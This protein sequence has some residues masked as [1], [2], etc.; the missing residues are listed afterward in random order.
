MNIVVTFLVTNWWLPALVGVAVVYFA[1]QHLAK[2]KAKEAITEYLHNAESSVFASADVGVPVVADA[3]YAMLPV[4][5]RLFLPRVLFDGIVSA[6]WGQARSA[7]QVQPASGNAAPEATPV[8]SAPATPATPAASSTSS[9][10]GTSST[11]PQK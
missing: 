4:A 5:V 10:S 11:T 2:G 7:L 8:A 6:L 3:V 1:L 9:P